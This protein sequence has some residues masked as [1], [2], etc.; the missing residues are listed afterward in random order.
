[1]IESSGFVHDDGGAGIKNE[2]I[3]MDDEKLFGIE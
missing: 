3:D 2:T 1:M